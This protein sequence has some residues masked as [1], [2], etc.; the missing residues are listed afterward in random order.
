MNIYNRTEKAYKEVLNILKKHKSIC[1]FD[2]DSL[3]KKSNSHLFGIELKE[4]Y[5]LNINPKDI[6]SLSWQTLREYLSIGWWGEK[7]HRR[8]ECPD[9]DSQPKNELLLKISLPSGAYIFGEDYPKDIFRK[10]FAELKNYNPKYIDT[11][12]HGLYF[13]MKNAGKIFNNFESVLKKYHE[14]NKENYK[15]REIKRMEK[16]LK[17]LKGN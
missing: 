5:G 15:K 7:Y 16:E 4:K 14:I 11:T 2:I 6:T 10:F 8:I 17:K 12:N 13:K 1:I 3:E 9:G